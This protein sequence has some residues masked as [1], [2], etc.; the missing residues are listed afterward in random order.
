MNKLNGCNTTINNMDKINKILDSEVELTSEINLNSLTENLEKCN[1]S[2]ELY[3]HV[4]QDKY[5]SDCQKSHENNNI[6]E[7]CNIVC[8]NGNSTNLMNSPDHDPCS[9]YVD[10]E[11]EKCKKE[12]NQFYQNLKSEFEKFCNNSSNR[13]PIKHIAHLEIEAS[14]K[15]EL[16]NIVINFLN[17][18]IDSPNPYIFIA[19]LNMFIHDFEICD[20]K[21]KE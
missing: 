6:N 11:N 12:V 7:N 1:I 16:E 5:G 21:T 18:R 10:V 2:N 3:A 4:N 20:F 17:K 15:K 14:K 19:E 9:D 8:T 13:S